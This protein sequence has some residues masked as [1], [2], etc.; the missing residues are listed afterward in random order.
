MGL[1][2]GVFSLPIVMKAKGHFP[3]NDRPYNEL[4]AL[5][6]N[7]LTIDPAPEVENLRFDGKK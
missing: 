5:R 4:E 2:N 7:P 3:V 1:G 6:I